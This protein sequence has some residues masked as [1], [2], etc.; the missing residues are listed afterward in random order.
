MN[1]SESK[2]FR[3]AKKMDLALISLLKKKSFEYITVSEICK[4]AEVNRSTFYLH[5][6]NTTD[7]LEETSRHI[8]DSFIEYFK[9]DM[10]TSVADMAN[11]ELNFI[12]EKYL[13]PYLT[14]IKENKEVFLT[15]L[16]H[17]KEFNLEYVYE[18]M[19]EYILNP[20]LERFHYPMKDRKYIMMYYLNG[21]NAISMEWAKNGCERK[22][23]EICSIIK[24]CVFG[25]N[26]PE[27]TD[28]YMKVAGNKSQKTIDKLS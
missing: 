19:F 9:P 28:N 16:L 21:I 22:P 2:Y 8:Q 25:L 23:E 17:M 1:R 26:I 7:L 6:E 14:Y 20:I 13:V 4:T 12:D 3:T 24:T 5:Y 10:M 27:K 11:Y 15:I 18:R